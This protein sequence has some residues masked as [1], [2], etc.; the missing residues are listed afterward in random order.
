MTSATIPVSTTGMAASFIQRA[1]AQSSRSN[2][3][4]KILQLHTVYRLHCCHNPMLNSLPPSRLV[5]EKLLFQIQLPGISF[6]SWLRDLTDRSVASQPSDFGVSVLCRAP[7]LGLCASRVPS[8]KRTPIASRS[9][10]IL[11][12][13]SPVCSAQARCPPSL[14]LLSARQT[15]LFTL[16]PLLKPNWH[17]STEGRSQLGEPVYQL[18]PVLTP[19]SVHVC[20]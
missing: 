14:K 4:C 6:C 15:A 17:R 2:H 11:A 7:F 20:T 19:D 13:S 5:A 16:N 10:H 8:K 1:H 9:A 18:S 12:V 3:Q